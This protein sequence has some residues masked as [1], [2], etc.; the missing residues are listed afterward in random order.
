LAKYAPSKSLY[1]IEYISL[2]VAVIDYTYR[3]D[4][5]MDDSMVLKDSERIRLSLEPLNRKILDLLIDKEMTITMLANS[6]KDKGKKGVPAPTILRRVRKLVEAG[7]IEQTRVG[8]PPQSKA[9][10]LLEKFYRTKARKFVVDTEISR[11]KGKEKPIELPP[12]QD[13]VSILESYGYGLPEQGKQDFASKVTEF[14]RLLDEKSK[15]LTTRRQSKGVQE[16]VDAKANQGVF[17][18]LLALEQSKDEKIAKL[19][20]EIKLNLKEQRF[21]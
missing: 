18:L 12:R 13:A 15:I 14:Q 9:K 10:N 11:M 4:H 5:P 17:Q 19:I 20:D 3:D 21:E 1:I 2:T 16:K 7:L 8:T 6:I